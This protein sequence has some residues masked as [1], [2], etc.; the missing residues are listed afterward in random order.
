MEPFPFQG[1]PGS[2][3]SPQAEKA[4]HEARRERYLDNA[5]PLAR[6]TAL[7]TAFGRSTATK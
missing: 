6:K 5:I 7:P 3:D 2:R 4:C 1:H